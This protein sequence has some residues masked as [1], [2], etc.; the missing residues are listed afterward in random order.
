MS[1]E[2]IY[3]DLQITVERNG[4]GAIVITAEIPNRRSKESYFHSEQFYGYSI[5]DAVERFAEEHDLDLWDS[6]DNMRQE[7]GEIVDVCP[8]EETEDAE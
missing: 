4:H 5:A 7:L 6:I 3:S 8:D 1:R 2:L